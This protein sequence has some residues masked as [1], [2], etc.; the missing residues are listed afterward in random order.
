M[1]PILRRENTVFIFQ[2]HKPGGSVHLQNTGTHLPAYE[3]D[4]TED[5][6]LNLVLSLLLHVENDKS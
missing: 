6:N 2:V 1:V 3:V 5:H 4:N